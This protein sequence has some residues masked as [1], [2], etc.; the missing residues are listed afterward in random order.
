MAAIAS[1]VAFITGELGA[2]AAPWLALQVCQHL[3]CAAK[4]IERTM[5]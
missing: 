4:A 3:G 2:G 1:P 5:R